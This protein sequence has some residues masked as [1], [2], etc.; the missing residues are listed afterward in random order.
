MNLLLNHIEEVKRHGKKLFEDEI[1]P[2]TIPQR[3][4]E[5]IY[6]EEDEEF[7]NVKIDKIPN[8]RSV[9]KKKEQSLLLMPLL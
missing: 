8:L 7:K 9:F 4:G 2:V 1:V 3:K 5:P 6:F